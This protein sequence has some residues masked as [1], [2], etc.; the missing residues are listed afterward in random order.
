MA[1][2]QWFFTRNGQKSGPVTAPTLRQL[3]AA[4]NLSPT[5]MVWR[6]GMS[7]WAPA[8]RVKGLFAEVAI[9]PPVPVSVNAVADAPEMNFDHRYNGLYRS[10]DDKVLLG[11]CGGLA[12]KFDAPAWVFRVIF[13][14]TGLVFIL[15]IILYFCGV[16][17]P[18]LPTK[19]APRPA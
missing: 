14:V 13:L 18:R 19:R 10:A 7:E 4:G 11:L 1:N 17:L 8:S 3:A 6:E 2:D 5:D 12:H 15:P 16:F 9:P